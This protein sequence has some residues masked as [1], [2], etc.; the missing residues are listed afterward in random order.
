MKIRTLIEMQSLRRSNLET[1]RSRLLR[2]WLGNVKGWTKL[3]ADKSN[4]QH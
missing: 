3:T 1:L 4:N 2:K